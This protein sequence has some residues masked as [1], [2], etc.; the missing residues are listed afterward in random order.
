MAVRGDVQVL[1]QFSPRLIIVDAPSTSILIQ[2]LVDTLRTLEPDLDN[3]DDAFIMDADGKGDLQDGNFVG[4]TLKLV[5][6][7]IGFEGRTTDI[8]NGTATTATSVTPA[9]ITLIDNVADFVTAGVKPG[10][11]VYN[12]DD[13]SSATI[14]KVIDLNTL[15]MLPLTGGTENDWDIGEHYHV[16]SVVKCSIRGGNLTAVTDLITNDPLDPVFNTPHV[17]VEIEKATS[18]VLTGGSAT[19]VNVED[20]RDDIIGYIGQKIP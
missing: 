15:Q 11:V 16:Y 1:W 14:V 19:I 5:N 9:G 17:S 2:D 4:I 6:A 12:F 10:D 18:A 3:M 20:S 8:A 13:H 7:K